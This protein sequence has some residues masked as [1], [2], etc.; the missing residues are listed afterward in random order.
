M[1]EKALQIGLNSELQRIFLE[2]V[3]ITHILS[4]ELKVLGLG[5]TI[6]LWGKKIDSLS[7][8]ANPI[9]ERHFSQPW[10]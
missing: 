6:Y 7:F 10:A 4:L 2:L 1:V 5:K 9:Q 8:Q 3:R